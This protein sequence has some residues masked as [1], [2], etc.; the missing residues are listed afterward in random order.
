MIDDAKAYL[1]SL[2]KPGAT[3]ATGRLSLPGQPFYEPASLVHTPHLPPRV[4]Q[5]YNA[6]SSEGDG[7]GWI[8]LGVVHAAETPQRRRVREAWPAR[9]PPE[10]RPRRL[11]TGR[12]IRA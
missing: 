10:R 4:L 7:D 11:S 2:G 12:S 5:P 3:P 1:R 8:R 6:R 9:S